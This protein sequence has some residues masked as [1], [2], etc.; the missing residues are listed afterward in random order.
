MKTHLKLLFVFGVGLTIASCVTKKKF[1]SL[2]NRYDTSV[3]DLVKCGDM[4]Q[5]YKERLTGMTR[6]Q[7]ESESQK[8]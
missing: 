4:M 5:D 2:Q 1:T 8:I 3:T 7:Q 6:M